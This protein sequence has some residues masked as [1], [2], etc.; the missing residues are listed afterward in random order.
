MI[1]HV[2]LVDISVIV[3]VCV[4]LFILRHV[5]YITKIYAKGVLIYALLVQEKDGE[6][7]PTDRHIR[8][9]RCEFEARTGQLIKEVH[10]GRIISSS[11]QT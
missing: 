3:K 9:W 2:P 6:S 1:W 4:F 8:T 11:L 10:N 5:S 7:Y